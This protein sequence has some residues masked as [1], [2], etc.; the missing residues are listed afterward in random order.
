MTRQAAYC[1]RCPSCKA[2]AVCPEC[3]RKISMFSP[4]SNWLRALPAPYDSAYVSLHN[5]D[6]IWHYYK[7]D[8]FITIEEKQFGG[9]SRD[10][11]WDTHGV[12]YQLLRM[13][14]DLGKG[15]RTGL[16]RRRIEKLVSYK[17]H[18]VIV[19]EKTNPDDSGWIRIKGPGAGKTGKIIT[20]IDLL[21]LLRT[22]DLNEESQRENQ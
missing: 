13:G 10:A 1:V 5:L 3:G 7:E 21:Y 12:V 14:S 6:F 9:K 19:F 15:I 11:Q 22:G 17:G 20:K 8:W 16:R 18:Y 2:D 4:F